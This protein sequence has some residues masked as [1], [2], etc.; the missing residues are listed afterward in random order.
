MRF[1]G[2]RVRGDPFCRPCHGRHHRDLH[3]PR[4]PALAGGGNDQWLCRLQAGLRSSPA[5]PGGRSPRRGGWRSAN[6]STRIACTAAWS[7]S[8][9]GKPPK[10]VFT[11]GCSPLDLK[12]VPE[13]ILKGYAK[14]WGSQITAILVTGRVTNTAK[15]AAAVARLLTVRNSVPDVATVPVRRDVRAFC[16]S[17]LRSACVAHEARSR[18]R[19]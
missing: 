17:R 11:G 9:R 10:L 16:S 1:A 3:R 12:A 15:Q 8:R 4:H 13:G 14:D 19:D 7:Y 18:R 6:G 5:A 2:I